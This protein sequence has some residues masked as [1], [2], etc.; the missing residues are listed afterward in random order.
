LD[1]WIAF[2]QESHPE[3]SFKNISGLLTDKWADD[4]SQQNKGLIFNP[5]IMWVINVAWNSVQTSLIVFLMYKVHWLVIMI[6]EMPKPVECRSVASCANLDEMFMYIYFILG[7]LLSL[8]C[9]KVCVVIFNR[10]KALWSFTVQRA[11]VRKLQESNE[12]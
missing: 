6:A 8:I 11:A 7:L 3:I 1:E 12:I 4:A 9:P 5:T 2:D 10:C